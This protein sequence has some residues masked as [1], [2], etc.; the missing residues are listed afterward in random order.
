MQPD[1][2]EIRDERKSTLAGSDLGDDPVAIGGVEGGRLSRGAVSDGR[3]GG[4]AYSVVVPT[5]GGLIAG[6]VVPRDETASLGAH[7]RQEDRHQGA[8]GLHIDSKRGG[9]KPGA[10][11]IACW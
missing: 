3:G 4:N 10:G 2:A 8:S 6:V 9:G 5:Y 1:E 11:G 7:G